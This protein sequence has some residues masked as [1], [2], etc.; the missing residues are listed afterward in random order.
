MKWD[1]SIIQAYAAYD[2]KPEYKELIEPML[3]EFKKLIFE[4]MLEESTRN[5]I[6]E[7]LQDNIQML[8]AA[9]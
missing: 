3:T 8:S 1:G 7:R 4:R 6:D 2:R 5:A 9:G